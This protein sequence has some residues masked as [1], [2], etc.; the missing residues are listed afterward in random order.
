M[1]QDKVNCDILGSKL[2]KY[3]QASLLEFF[4]RCITSSRR[5]KSYSREEDYYV[6]GLR[7]TPIY[8][9]YVEYKSVLA[10]S[11]AKLHERSHPIYPRVLKESERADRYT[12]RV[13]EELT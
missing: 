12:S 5:L 2:P 13:L 11:N 4:V 8:A 7:G 9:R 3:M 1:C 10:L 6:Q